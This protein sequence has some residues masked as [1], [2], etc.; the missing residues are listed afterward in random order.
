MIELVD[1][2]IQFCAV[3]LGCIWSGML[4]LKNRHQPYFL[5]SCFYGCFALGLLYWILYF[6]LFGETPDLFYVSEI[7]WIASFVLL[8]LLQFT[9]SPPLLRSFRCKVAYLAPF[10]GA[11]LLVFYILRGDVF[12]GILRCA[13]MTALAW[14]GIRAIA[15]YREE[16]PA[17]KQQAR[18]RFHRAILAFVVLENC[19]WISSSFW[20]GDTLANPYFWIDFALTGCLISFLPVMRKTVRV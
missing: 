20:L 9:L 10:I 8:Y 3:L 14:D 6:I 5:L 12:S 2:L 13:V 11:V 16:K 1:N 7:I 19:L 18:C 4:Y 15:F 17:S